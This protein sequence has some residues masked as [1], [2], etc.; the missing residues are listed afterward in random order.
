MMK[1]FSLSVRSKKKCPGM[2]GRS[3][4]ICAC[5][6]ECYFSCREISL[7]LWEES[8]GYLKNGIRMR[9]LT[10]GSWSIRY[11]KGRRISCV[12]S[13]GYTA[14]S[15][16]FINLILTLEA[17]IGL[18]AVTGKIVLLVL[19]VEGIIRKMILWLSL[20][21]PLCRGIIIA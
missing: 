8:L 15:R 13:I 11:I 17:S 20:I 14:M 2:S 3:L 1:S 16:R 4:L 5:F 12:S 9:A 18:I 6:L 10:G 19:S 7:P 21:L